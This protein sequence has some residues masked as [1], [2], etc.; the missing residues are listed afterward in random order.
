VSIPNLDQS[1]RWNTGH[2]GLHWV[3]EKDRYDRMLRPFLEILLEAAHLEPGEDL[4]DVGCGSGATTLAAAPLVAPGNAVG[5]DLSEPLLERARHD[6]AKRRIENVS[7]DSGDAQ[8]LQ[9]GASFDVVISRFGV[10][11]FADPAA[12][13]ANLH[14]AS[15]S[16]G[17]FVFVCWQP[18]IEN[19]WLLVPGAALAEHVALPEPPP[20][21]SPGMFGLSD[22]DR[23]RNLLAGAGW[24]DVTVT[25]RHTPMLL[26]GGGSVDDTLAFLRSGSMARTMLNGV[27]ADTEAGAV[28]SVRRELEARAD[29]DGVRLDA[30]VWLVQ[31]RA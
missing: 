18:M 1:D 10:M 8:V 23:V 6:A 22:P 15:R 31:A 2:D 19:D 5:L 17:R 29:G 20:P 4:L 13:F 27:D 16:G 9:F 12:A 28:R 30:A 21:N 14:S 7:F 26:G 25:S 3:A 11:F 24:N